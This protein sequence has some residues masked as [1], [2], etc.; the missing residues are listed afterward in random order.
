MDFFC[1]F[2]VIPKH[3]ILT[4]I[5]LLPSFL[6]EY[7]PLICTAKIQLSIEATLSHEWILCMQS[8]IFWATRMPMLLIP[9]PTGKSCLNVKLKWCYYLTRKVNLSLSCHSSKD[10]QKMSP[11]NVSISERKKTDG[12]L[13]S[14]AR[15]KFSWIWS[16]GL[17][18]VLI[19]YSYYRKEKKITS[20][21]PGETFLQW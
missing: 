14:T 21:N 8:S 7:K 6:L 10:I 17:L 3:K 13:P 5:L 1:N 16:F 18:K 19:G 20:L 11:W 2:R 15:A 9:Q 12:S 4:F